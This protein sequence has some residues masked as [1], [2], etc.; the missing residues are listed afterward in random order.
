MCDHARI[1][2]IEFLDDLTDTIKIKL[3]C[4]HCRLVLG[5]WTKPK[6]ALQSIYELELQQHYVFGTV[7]RFDAQ[8]AH[9]NR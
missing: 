5:I 4:Q 9:D 1:T 6:H 8:T 2:T 7:K 3:L